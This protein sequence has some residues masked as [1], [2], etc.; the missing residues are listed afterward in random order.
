MSV[1]AKLAIAPVERLNEERAEPRQRNFA[2]AGP[3]AGK[4]D[5]LGGAAPQTLGDTFRTRK[6][7]ARS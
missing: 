1:S 5:Q 3:R 7:R 4:S 2:P 6:M